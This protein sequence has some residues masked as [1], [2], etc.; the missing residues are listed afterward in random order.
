MEECHVEAEAAEPFTAVVSNP[1]ADVSAFFSFT[2]N[3]DAHHLQSFPA[4][5]VHE[6]HGNSETWQCAT[7]GA[8]DRT[9]A[10]PAG[11]RFD[12]DSTTMRAAPG[13]GGDHAHD[14]DSVELASSWGNHPRCVRCGG[15]ARP[16]I[17]MF[18]DRAY[19]HD[20]ASVSRF[21]SWATA[22]EE[23]VERE[24][25]A[26]RR[27]RVVV[28][29][30]GAGDN[31]RTVRQTSETLLRDVVGAGGVPTL[32][33]INPDLPLADDRDLQ[34]HTL[35]LMARPDQTASRPLRRPRLTSPANA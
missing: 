10:A 25:A 19:K 11:F 24:T 16:N 17:L 7:R 20:E 4:G 5:E 23:H 31:V 2:S 33:R 32:I 15:P 29:E 22:V 6:C 3:V 21:S 14:G 26:G 27:C 8:C 13:R 34:A 18:E 1:L 12:V 28:L 30:I 35:S 9:W